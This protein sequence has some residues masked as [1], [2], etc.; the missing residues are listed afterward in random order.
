MPF[1]KRAKD[2]KFILTKMNPKHGLVV[3][4]NRAAD[5]R[6]LKKRRQGKMDEVIL[7]VLET[8]DRPPVPADI[9]KTATKKEYNEDLSYMAAWRALNHDVVRQKRQV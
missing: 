9:I 3:R 4:P 1:S 6:Q 2:E 8:K 5:G 7:R